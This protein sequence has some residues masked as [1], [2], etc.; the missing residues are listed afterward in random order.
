MQDDLVFGFHFKFSFTGVNVFS[1][2]RECQEI[3]RNPQKYPSNPQK[4]QSK[5]TPSKNTRSYRNRE[6]SSL[7]NTRSY[8][9]RER[10]SLLPGERIHID[11]VHISPRWGLD[12]GGPDVSINIPPRWGCLWSIQV[13]FSDSCVFVKNFQK[14]QD[15]LKTGREL[16]RNCP[17]YSKTKYP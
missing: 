10:S 3:R 16:G 1:Q 14:N 11:K 12:L 9:N 7:L 6:R 13:Y 2:N 8:R 17:N 4:Y 5:N 15:C